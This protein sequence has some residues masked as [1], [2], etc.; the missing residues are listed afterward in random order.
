MTSE[1]LPIIDI[2][3]AEDWQNWIDSNQHTAGAWLKLAKKNSGFPTVVYNDILDIAL[4]Y[5]WIDGQRNGFDEN[6][7][8]QKFTPRRPKSIW[9]KRNVDK[10][11]ML[12]EAGRMTPAGIAEVERAKQDGRWDAAYD[13]Q[14]MTVPED[15][16]EALAKD[17]KAL[18]F[19]ENLNSANK[20]AIG[21]RLATA[22][23]P[24]TRQRRFEK[25]LAM[26]QNGEKIH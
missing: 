16:K 26:M 19:F 14:N 7:F 2:T 20:F 21:F 1:T 25:L 23:K 9:S 12:T 6:F 13:G 3:S 24:E 22:K 4:C 15:F 8:L 18:E 17:P 5:G 11:A 10:I